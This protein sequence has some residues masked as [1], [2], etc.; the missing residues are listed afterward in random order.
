MQPTFFQTGIHQDVQQVLHRT[1]S[2]LLSSTLISSP[3]KCHNPFLACILLPIGCRV[4]LATSTFSS[5]CITSF[6]NPPQKR[7]APH[8]AGVHLA[9]NLAPQLLSDQHLLQPVHEAGQPLCPKWQ[10]DEELRAPRTAPPGPPAA[11]GFPWRPPRSAARSQPP[12]SGT[13]GV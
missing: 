5:L 10:R 7:F 13:P 1:P 9:P 3:R 8:L 4:V 12:G 2:K 11:D 6:Q